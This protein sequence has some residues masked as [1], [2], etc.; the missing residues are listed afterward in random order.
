[1]IASGDDAETGL[2]RRGRCRVME[3]VNSTVREFETMQL[4]PTQLARVVL[5]QRISYRWTQDSVFQ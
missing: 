1:M 3:K 4:E 2:T 5:W